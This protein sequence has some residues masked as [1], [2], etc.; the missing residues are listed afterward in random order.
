[1][2]TRNAAT[3]V[4]RKGTDK[5]TRA[6]ITTKA[7]ESE[8]AELVSKIQLGPESSNPP[9]LF[10]LPEDA[11]PEAR[12]ISLENPRYS[13][14]DRYFV[15]P[16]K[17]IY[18]FTKVAAPKTTPRSWLLAPA[19]GDNLESDKKTHNEDGFVMRDAN[20]FISTPI[21]PLFLL[22]TVLNPLSK[23]SEASKKLFLSG[24]DYLDKLGEA[25][26][27]LSVMLRSP[28]LRKKFEDRMKVACETV[29]AGDET[30]YRW[31][32]EKLL[33]EL[34][35][36]AKKMIEKGLPASME[37]KLI[38]KPLEVPIL[39]VKRED[40]SLS[41]SAK[42]GEATQ[43]DSID[44]SDTQ[45]TTNSAAESL[46]TPF[47]ETS[48]ATTSFSE[49]E[50]GDMSTPKAKTSAPDG[51]TE[52]LRLR[53]AFL[54]ISSNYIPLYISTPLKKAL[55]SPES[56]VDFKP[57]DTYLEHLAKLRQDALA[58]RSLGDY[59]RK[60][61]I[62]DDDETIEHRAEKKRKREEEDKRKKAGVSVGLRKLQKVNTTGMKKMSDFFKKK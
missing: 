54:F 59:S 2:R 21:D 49:L 39:S 53:T 56:P 52:L 58:L 40:S 36:K 42:D 16:D 62:D 25:S 13:T 19:T 32:E 6:K 14:E 17:G 20:L 15:C 4:P 45:S 26:P 37:E 35:R 28:V 34:L 11:S 43:A 57:L 44:L 33:Q 9:L 51:V 23:A 3:E 24:D 31:S 46:P 7:S 30:M 27:H 10:I 50:N 18:E 12:V 48:T 61:D 55:C 5:R 29:E 60:R 1:M 22:L 8:A 47:S 41:E 38:K